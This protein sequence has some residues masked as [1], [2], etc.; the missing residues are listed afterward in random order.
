MSGRTRHL[1]SPCTRVVVLPPNEVVVT[2]ILGWATHHSLPSPAFPPLLQPHPRLCH[3]PLEEGS[4]V[5]EHRRVRSEL[6]Q[7]RPVLSF[8]SKSVPCQLLGLITR[9]PSHPP[10]AMNDRRLGRRATGHRLGYARRRLWNVND[11][12]PRR[13]LRPLASLNCHSCPLEPPSHSHSTPHQRTCVASVVT[14]LTTRLIYAPT[15]AQYLGQQ[16]GPL[17]QITATELLQI[18]GND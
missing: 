1:W 13:V 3:L 16:C 15:L 17:A 5:S 10:S 12:V 4:L 7:L 8:L 14:T 11:R 9:R 18:R 6:S 2:P